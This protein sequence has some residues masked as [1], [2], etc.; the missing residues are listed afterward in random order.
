MEIVHLLEFLN[1][2]HGQQMAHELFIGVSW[3]TVANL[4]PGVMQG[5]SL[6]HADRQHQV[7]VLRNQ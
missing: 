4:R 2:L 5:G 1:W 3:W 6:I 7:F